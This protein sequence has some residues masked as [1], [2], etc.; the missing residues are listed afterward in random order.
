MGCGSPV[1]NTPKGLESPLSV[2]KVT[3]GWVNFHAGFRFSDIDVV[4]RRSQ[5]C[6]GTQGPAYMEI[7]TS[8]RRDE[9]LPLSIAQRKDLAHERWESLPAVIKD[10]FANAPKVAMYEALRRMDVDTQPSRAVEWAYPTRKD[11]LVVTIWHDQI[12][13]D[14]GADILYYVPTGSW[15]RNSNLLGRSEQMREH[16]ARFAGQSVT[17]LLLRHQ[18]DKNDTQTAKSVAPDMKRWLIEQVAEDEFI[19]WRGRCADATAEMALP[20]GVE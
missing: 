20:V 8:L 7:L 11:S 1:R 13:A 12:R 17:A 16:L 15:G 19:L 5:P 6:N 18:W 2:P 9:A 4:V 3:Q 14:M 10:T